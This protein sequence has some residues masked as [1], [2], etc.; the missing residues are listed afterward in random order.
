[1][2]KNIEFTATCS[3]IEKFCFKLQGIQGSGC[4]ETAP[5]KAIHG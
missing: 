1:M 4:K 2:Q 5:G 3:P